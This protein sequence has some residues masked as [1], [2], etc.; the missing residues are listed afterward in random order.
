[1]SSDELR[2]SE[3]ESGT[4]TNMEGLGKEQT[5]DHIPSTSNSAPLQ[6]AE[7]QREE[8][9]QSLQSPNG[10]KDQPEAEASSKPESQE[11]EAAAKA[12]ERRERFK[13]LQARAKSGTKHNLRET[14]AEA[15]RLSQD[16]NA[17]NSVNRKHAF[18]SHNLL[19]ADTEASGEDF[20]RKRAWDWTIEESER[21][22]RRMEKKARHR[23]DTSFS[24]Y[25]QDARKTYKRQLR[26][27]KPDLEAYEAEKIAAVERAARS[28]GLEI[29]EAE[30]GELVAIDR[31]GTFYR[32]ADTVNFASEASKPKRE[33]VDRLVADLRK[34]EEVRLK[35]RKDKDAKQKELEDGEDITYINDKNK[36]F[37]EQLARFYNK[38]TAE[39]RESFE[40]GT[41]I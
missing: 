40:R 18:A 38:Y 7:G 11:T 31:D 27:L 10:S 21:W 1:M 19:K 17:L 4:R 30:D 9:Q 39:I 23:E 12:R 2:K 5:Q 20:E 3:S 22:D 29:V 24:D 14:A 33:A 36:K 13:A 37:N 41:M 6:P 8:D 26:N 35:K 25:R 16:P 15:H 28:G 32:T 34:A